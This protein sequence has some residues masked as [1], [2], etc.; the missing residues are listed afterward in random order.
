QGHPH[1]AAQRTDQRGDQ[2][3]R[4]RRRRGRLHHQTVCADGAHRAGQGPDRATGP[5]VSAMPATGVPAWQRPVSDFPGLLHLG[6]PAVHPRDSLSAVISALARDPNA[7]SVFVIADDD[8]LLGAIPE[9]RLDAALVKLALP[10]PLWASLG[11]LDPRGLLLAAKGTSQTA[12]D[13]M[14][15]CASVTPDSQ[16]KDVLAGMVRNG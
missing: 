15:R 10:Q 6:P 16:L 7:R 3:R 5:G 4:L 14:V 9:R 11:D 2:S 8:R 12:R 1:C 13:L